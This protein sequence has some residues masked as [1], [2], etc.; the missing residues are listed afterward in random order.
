MAVNIKEL[1]KQVPLIDF[2]H[3]P[4]PTWAKD[5]GRNSNSGKWSGTFAGYFS[6]I[7]MSFGSCTQEQMDI[8]K[9]AF[10]VAVCT[11]T[12]PDSKGGLPATEPF[13]GTAINGKKNSWNGKYKPFN[14]TLTALNPYEERIK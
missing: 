4:N 5:S 8:I 14:L 6:T 2:E 10:E 1:S 9:N 13:Y 12:Y 7:N 11:V 3:V